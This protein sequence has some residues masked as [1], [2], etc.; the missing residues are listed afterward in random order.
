MTSVI[1]DDNGVMARMNSAGGWTPS[2][3]ED[4]HYITVDFGKV[5]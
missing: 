2:D 3:T 5:W 1:D 4:D